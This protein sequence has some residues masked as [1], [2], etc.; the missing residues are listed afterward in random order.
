MSPADGYGP[1]TDDPVSYQR[2]FTKIANPGPA[3][4]YAFSMTTFLWALYLVN[5]R[6]VLNDDLLTGLALFTGGLVQFMAGMW[7]FP[8]GNVFGATFFSL[9]GAFWM[10]YALILIPVFGIATSYNN[11]NEFN[12]A[13]GLY[14]MVWFMLS[15]FLLL[16]VIRRNI[17]FSVMLGSWALA[18]LLLAIS[19]FNV[20]HR[21]GKAGGA[22]SF[23]T[24][25]VGFYIATSQ[26]M[27]AE[28]AT[29]FRMPLGHL[30]ARD[31]APGARGTAG[32]AV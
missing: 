24:A 5:T 20:T 8:R 17:S 28:H 1:R 31:Y 14:L 21:D 12:N 32:R 15:F 30:G 9:Y 11:G 29:M 26:L 2:Y 27:H 6:G 7:E 22:F 18:Y 19:N 3:G 25:I 16:T 10:S 23:V 4:V 13:F